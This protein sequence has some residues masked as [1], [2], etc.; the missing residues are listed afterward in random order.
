MIAELEWGGAQQLLLLL[1]CGVIGLGF[2][3]A[4]DLMTGLWRGATRSKRFVVD[5]VFCLLAAL[6]TFYCSLILTDG[7]MHPILFMGLLAGA[8]LEHLSV[9]R[10][11]SK[12]VSQ[13]V[14]FARRWLARVGGFTASEIRRAVRGWLKLRRTWAGK[15]K[16]VKKIRKKRHFFQ[17]KS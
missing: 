4:F 3:V 6:V 10:W 17:K 12:W 11:V 8:L 14:R 13:G 1:R 15:V 16:N 2:G 5:V 7:K 9:G